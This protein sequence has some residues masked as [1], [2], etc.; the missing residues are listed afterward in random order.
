MTIEI[1][2]NIAS[3][4]FIHTPE[5]SWALFWFTP[6]G[7]LVLQSDW[8]TYTHNWRSF[9]GDFEKFLKSLDVEY[10]VG[11]L[12][13]QYVNQTRT[14]EKQKEIL[15]LLFVHFKAVLETQEPEKPSLELKQEIISKSNK[16]DELHEKIGKVYYDE[17]FQG[18][19]TDIGEIAALKLGYLI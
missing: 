3:T 10:F 9:G 1:K 6:K 13:T 5:T 15:R 8:G 17:N 12:S 2:K 16:W 14:H 19:L 18:D 11:K 4:V 7:D